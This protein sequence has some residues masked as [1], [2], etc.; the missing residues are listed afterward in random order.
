MTTV[1]SAELH[2]ASVAVKGAIH[3]FT[4]TLAAPFS[5][6]LPGDCRVGVSAVLPYCC[7][8]AAGD[9]ELLYGIT[10][11][12]TSTRSDSRRSTIPNRGKRKSADVQV[13]RL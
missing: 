1:C 7:N 2:G 9:G 3:A 4:C 6:V 10:S 12:A 8:T 13:D 11:K 5:S